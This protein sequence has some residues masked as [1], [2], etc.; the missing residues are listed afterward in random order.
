MKKRDDYNKENIQKFADLKNILLKRLETIM[1][2]KKEM[3]PKIEL[4]Q[5]QL[6]DIV[7]SFDKVKERTNELQVSFNNFLRLG[8]DYKS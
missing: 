5:N 2:K 3:D 7:K 6:K 8:E 4:K 1:E